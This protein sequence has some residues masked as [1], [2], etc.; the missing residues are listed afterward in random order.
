MDPVKKHPGIRIADQGNLLKFLLARGTAFLRQLAALAAP[1]ACVAL[2]AAIAR[3]DYEV[4]NP[5]YDPP[6]GYYSSATGTGT[7]LRSN[8]HTII[9]T[10]FN[11]SSY[12]DSRT[13][14]PILWQDP[15][16][17]NNMILV[18]N[19]AVDR[20]AQPQWDQ[21]VGP[22]GL[23]QRHHL[24][25]RTPLAAIYSRRFRFQHLQRPC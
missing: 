9:S 13:I 7:T 19:N 16:N 18:Y 21:P 15:N 20:Q 8:L 3:A 10:G 4:P 12:G 14:L 2:C 6:A 23:G 24:E 22:P 1:A 11:T 25:S 17:S 5:A